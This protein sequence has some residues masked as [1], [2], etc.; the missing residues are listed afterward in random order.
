MPRILP[1][2]LLALFLALD[3][4][5]EGADGVLQK[6]SAQE[7]RLPTVEILISDARESGLAVDYP[8]ADFL[9]AKR[10]CAYAREDVANDRLPRAQE[11]VEELTGL[12]DRAEREARAGV[13]VP[14]LLPG[15]MRIED[16]AFWAS[17]R[18]GEKEEYRPVF[19]TGYGHGDPAIEDIPLFDK[20]GINV[21]QIEQGPEGVV[22]ADGTVST[23]L[24]TDRLIPALDRARDH[25]VMLNL[26]ISPHYFP[27]W[28]Y[29]KRPALKVEPGA[30]G[31]QPFLKNSIEA[32]EAREIYERY[33]RT[34]IPLVKDHP[35]LHSICLSN[36]PVYDKHQ[37]DSARVPLWHQYIAATHG[38]IDRLNELYGTR[39]ES[40]NQVPEPPLSFREIPAA[41]YDV[42]RFNQTR[43]AG[44][45]RW[46][47]DIIHEMA[48]NLE[49]HAKMMPLVWDRDSVL[50]GTDPLEFAQLGRINGN[51]CYFVPNGDASP[52]ASDWLVQGMFYDLQ[53]S[54]AHTPI[55]NSENHVIL[56]R[57]D[58]FVDASHIYTAIWQGAIHGQGASTTWI[59]GRTYDKKSDL[60]G[61]TLHRAACTAAMSRSALD[62]M[63]LSREVFTLQN[64]EPEVAILWSNA[65]QVHDSRVASSRKNVYEALNFL[66]I[67]IGFVHEK[68][69]ADHAVIG[70]KCLIVAGAAAITAE[71][72]Q[73]IRDF[74]QRGGV[75]LAYGDDNLHKDE[76]GRNVEP[77]AFAREISR[78]ERGKDLS[79][80]FKTEIQRAGVKPGID[81]VDKD[82]KLPYGVEWRS[83]VLDGHTLINLVNFSRKPISVKL[84]DCAW[85]DLITLQPLPTEITLQT[86]TPVLAKGLPD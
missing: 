9:I 66:G 23:A 3:A 36:E 53:R 4:Q 69:L 75:V 35:A 56:D 34:L 21:I 37:S 63:R 84:P 46:M 81:L 44:W 83:A 48:P 40:F 10:F 6:I 22:N 13:V 58:F 26:L 64:Q 5:G 39:H 52:W 18:I 16:G 54:M 27:A 72:L 70:L 47:V 57:T 30:P 59:W 7:A 1:T 17:C 68:Q 79:Q 12:L 33:L 32:A 76:Y 14:R 31:T 73:G 25:G 42:V 82:G 49:C 67:P 85:Q 2:A 11:V 29:E 43:F 65:A 19:L 28:A 77:P 15:T 8:A 55:F 62:L 74:I 20:I 71:G 60:E 80:I 78:S 38:E 41:L 50:W 45:H 51:D 24:I 86:N 61:L